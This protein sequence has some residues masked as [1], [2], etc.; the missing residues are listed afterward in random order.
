LKETP[1]TAPMHADRLFQNPRGTWHAL[2]VGLVFATVGSNVLWRSVMFASQ[3]LFVAEVGVG[4]AVEALK[5]MPDASRFDVFA[6]RL[7]QLVEH[8]NQLLVLLV[9]AH[10]A[11]TVTVLPFYQHLSIPHIV[12]CYAINR[13][14]SDVFHPD[15][16]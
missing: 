8:A 12:V 10:Y 15:I 1:S 2:A 16:A 13:H 4:I 11:D 5:Q 9:D 3:S 14:F 7:V 6:D